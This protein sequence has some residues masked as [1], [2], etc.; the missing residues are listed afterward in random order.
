MREVG[1][2]TEV[3]RLREALRES[4]ADIIPGGTRKVRGINTR[5][6]T[7]V[8]QFFPSANVVLLAS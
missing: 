4:Q 1:L 3:T 2:W 8:V 5:R 6:D 7:R